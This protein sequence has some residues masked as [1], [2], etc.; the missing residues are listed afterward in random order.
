MLSC[1]N[2]FILGTTDIHLQLEEAIA[3]FMRMEEGIVYSY[4]FVAI[5][6]SIAAYCKRNDVVFVDKECNFP[7]QQG[8]AAARCNV[9]YFDHN[10]P[11][12]FQEE[13]KKVINSEKNKKPSRKF[14]IVEG[15][16]WKSGKL[17][18]LPEFLKVAE[19]YKIRIFLDETY[20]IGIFGDHGK[21]L[22]EHFDID[23]T[24]I[25]MIMGTLEAAIGSIGGFCVGSQLTIDHQRLSGS[26]YI[27]SASQPT[28]LV[29]AC[30]ESLKLLGNKPKKLRSLAQEFHLF[31]KESC[32]FTVKSDP[33]C[34]FQVFSSGHTKNVEIHE[35]CKTNGVHFI[36]TDNDLVIN[37]NVKLFDNNNNNLD[38]VYDCLKKASI[39][40]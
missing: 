40:Q 19:E 9:K 10:N 4:G 28:F 32:K 34:P 6:S 22:T 16:S 25:D 7:I 2:I 5:S 12:S 23:P 33:Q 1:L 35:F 18:P 21:G 15:I 29:Q 37:L 39:L 30:L 17:L 26:G 36:K 27:F 31:L 20:S 13:V 11:N 3:E 14:L 24:R 8:L 38:K